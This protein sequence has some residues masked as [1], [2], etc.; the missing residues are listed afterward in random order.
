MVPLSFSQQ[1][2]V[3][4]YFLPSIF[5]KSPTSLR[6]VLMVSTIVIFLSSNQ[7]A[8]LMGFLKTT[9]QPTTYHRRP[10]NWPTDQP[11]TYHRPPI[12]DHRPTDLRPIRNMRTRNSMKILKWISDKKTWDRIINTIS[13][14]CI[15]I[16][17]LKP[18]C[19]IEKIKSLKV[20]LIKYKIYRNCIWIKSIKTGENY[21]ETIIA[22][23][24][25]LNFQTAN[26]I[27][28][29]LKL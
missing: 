8:N 6:L 22:H 4:L 7:L 25:Q 20:K 12:T 29:A 18:E 28:A 21:A 10:T 3:L 15:I 27:K 5:F 2:S 17:L 11:T 16:F 26:I 9:D 24:A 19:V 14:M 23:R 1:I 13:R